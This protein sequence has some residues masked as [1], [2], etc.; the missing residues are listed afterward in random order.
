MLEE[1][2]HLYGSGIGSSYQ[3]Q[4]ETLS[5]YFSRPQS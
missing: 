1:P 4:D 5:K 3:Q 2:K